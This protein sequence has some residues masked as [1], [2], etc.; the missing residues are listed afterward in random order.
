MSES[1]FRISHPGDLAL[2]LQQAYAEA[3]AGGRAFRLVLPAFD[4][5]PFHVSLGSIGG[6]AIDLSVEGE[7]ERPVTL[8]GVSMLLC[9]RNVTI[10]NLSLRGTR[11]PTSALTVQ[12]LDS[13]EGRRLGFIEIRR[14]DPMSNEPIVQVSAM[15]PRDRNALVSL[16]DCWFIGNE[17]EGYTAVLSTPRTG[18]AFIERLFIERCAFLGNRTDVGIDPW[19]S[20]KL[21][22][23]SVFV[24][25][26]DVDAWL[27]LR[28]PLVSVS[29]SDSFL[30][31]TGKLVEFVT[32]PDVAWTGF[33]P[34]AARRC[35]LLSATPIGPADV[36]GSECTTGT[37]LAAPAGRKDVIRLSER[38]PDRDELEAAFSKQV[39]KGL[40]HGQS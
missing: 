38:P 3:L 6:E 17:G 15:G 19:F 4:Y 8:H 21:S 7:G 5:E 30:S 10:G 16:S 11:T 26:N 1:V 34:V 22:I 20:R 31:S 18:R 28:S 12:V 36:A 9:G 37:P 24:L 25:E 2:P 35:R 13:F 23:D 29:L 14:H 27:R 32:S 39:G 33:S 40:R